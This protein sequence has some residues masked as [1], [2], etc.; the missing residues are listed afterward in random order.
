MVT[1]GVFKAHWRQLFAEGA[2][3]VWGAN[4]E[5]ITEELINRLHEAYGCAMYNREYYEDK[6]AKHAGKIAADGPGAIFPLSTQDDTING[7]YRHQCSEKGPISQLPALTACLVFSENFLHV[8]AYLGDG[9]VVEMSN[10]EDNCT[11]TDFDEDA[12]AWYGIPNWLENPARDMNHNIDST[13]V[14]NIQKWVNAYLGNDP[15][16]ITGDFNQ[17]TKVGLCKCLQKCLKEEFEA[18]ELEINGR[19]GNK[20]KAACVE[21]SRSPYLTYICHAMLCMHN[22]YVGHSLK[23]R[24]FVGQC[25]EGSKQSVKEFQQKTRGLQQDGICGPATFYAMFNK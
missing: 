6:L 25:S 19:F 15:I 17:Q 18:T 12:W 24:D 20:T 16:K 1:Q 3:Y 13:V 7:Y 11:M 21:A 5:P 22:V 10:N 8:G 4:C 9:T 2:I 14:S 23:D